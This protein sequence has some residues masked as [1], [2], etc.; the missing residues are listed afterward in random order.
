[1][2]TELWITVAK[3]GRGACKTCRDKVAQG[4]IKIGTHAQHEREGRGFEKWHHAECFWTSLARRYAK[5]TQNGR[6]AADDFVGFSALALEHRTAFEAQLALSNAQL[7]SRSDAAK[8]KASAPKTKR[9]AAAKRKK[10]ADEERDSGDGAGQKGARDGDAG[11]DGVD[12]VEE[13]PSKESKAS[14]ARKKAK[15]NEEEYTA[16]PSGKPSAEQMKLIMT[17]SVAQL[18]D[19]LKRNDQIISGAKAQLQ[20][21]VIDCIQH[22]VY[23]KCPRC[24]TGRLRAVGNSGTVECPGHFDDEGVYHRCGFKGRSSDVE[25]PAWAA[26][27]GKV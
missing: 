3:T 12:T 17:A 2:A 20:D 9:A 14:P 1:M 23:P 10:A 15:K 13:P 21:R 11:V 6:L 26:Q 18:K 4:G 19:M 24:F 5:K 22:G 7:G 8:T 25:R 16:G 27:E